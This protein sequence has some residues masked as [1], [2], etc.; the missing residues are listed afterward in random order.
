MAR[1]LKYKGQAVS[2]GIASGPAVLLRRQFRKPECKKIDQ[3]KVANEVERLYNA[4]DRARTDIEG[5]RER[6]T[7]GLGET[8]ARIF[9]A[10][11]MI[12][13][14]EPTFEIVIQ[15]INQDLCSAE[16]ALFQVFDG[17]A[18]RFEAQK[19][20][21]FRDRAQDV[22]EVCGRILGHLIG[23]STDTLLDIDEPSILIASELGPSDVLQLDPERI[24][25]V[26]ADKG[27]ATSHTAILTRA[28]G[29]PSVVGLHDITRQAKPG[30]IVVVN[31]NSGK[32][33]LRPTQR[34][35]DR[36]KE[37]ETQ[38]RAF[39][40]SLRD[41]NELPAETKDGRKI[42]LGANI[43][44]PG[45]ARNVARFGGDGIGLYRTEYLFL[46]Q[47]TVPS[48]E[49]QVKE[50]T[51]VVKQLDGKPLVI[52]TFDLGGDK[53][54]PAAG[55][56]PEANPFMGWRAIRVA[57]DRPEIFV[58]QL[59]AIL[60]AS[61]HGPI[62]VMFPMISDM[63]ELKLAKGL[64]E[65]A[66]SQLRDEGIDYD[67]DM[68]VGIMIEVPS[69]AILADQFAKEVD[70][71]SI[72]TNDLA[73]FTL[74]VDRGN[75]QVAHLH[76]VYHPSV[77]FLISWTVEA[78]HHHNIPVALCGEF[79]GDPAASL[80]LLGLGL[81]EISMSPVRIPEIKKLIRSAT[82][83]EAYEITQK[84]LTSKSS[85]E[86]HDRL[87]RRMKQRFA[88]LPIWFGGKQ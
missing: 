56:P 46:A 13:E 63:Q 31:G 65:E 3:A 75:E 54:F 84:V 21:I 4:I 42:H 19:E 15:Q 12:L 78:A 69:T 38:Y 39:V 26:A 25:G 66:K 28:L 41:I 67:P 77:L 6:A 86:A 18:N 40:R 53:V 82:Q 79:A 81:D 8:V 59:R 10:H 11:L 9:D 50:Y 2:P 57:L 48:E 71:F 43:E 68:K 58:T 44:L 74:A 36:Y 49:Q 70:F 14:D 29:V 35:L 52:R 73:Q 16:A 61:V 87:V 80:L 32:V 5:Q 72:G 7:K 24:I 33:V 55:I 60:R 1:Q 30:N 64:F 76:T 47:D 22:R 83:K 88:E 34:N 17:F 37:K 62:K 45:E 27:G 20:Q 23:R 51:E 85:R